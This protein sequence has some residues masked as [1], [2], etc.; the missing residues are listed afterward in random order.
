MW[1]LTDGRTFLKFIGAGGKQMALGLLPF[2]FQIGLLTSTVVEDHI[3]WQFAN[4]KRLIR[5]C[6][7]MLEHRRVPG[8]GTAM[9]ARLGGCSECCAKNLKQ[10]FCLELNN[11][12]AQHS[13]Y[14]SSLSALGVKDRSFSS[15]DILLRPH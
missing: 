10:Q 11:L 1:A 15:P 14:D 5:M 2:L 13:I 4:A 8:T 9:T 3:N 7:F 12:T 6:S